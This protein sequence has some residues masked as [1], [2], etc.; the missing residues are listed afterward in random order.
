MKISIKHL[1]IIS[2]MIT[3]FWG[4]KKGGG[5]PEPVVSD[6]TK[7]TISIT[8]PIA[9]QVF[10]PGN[11]IA[12]HASFTDNVKLKSYNIAIIKVVTGGFILKNVPSPVAWSYTKPAT[13][14]N[15]GVKQQDITLNDIVIPT[16]ING[17]PVATGNYNFQVSCIDDSGNAT[18]TNLVIKLN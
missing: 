2:L 15:S 4:C 1:I 13:N 10:A 9:G 5:T 16:D 6:T 8:N 12:F 14:F 3:V 7:P 11:T 17:S 18:T